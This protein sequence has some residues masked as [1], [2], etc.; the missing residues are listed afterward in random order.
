MRVINRLI[1]PSP[2]NR[3]STINKHLIVD[4]AL[5]KVARTFLDN[6]A[7][8][9]FSRRTC[10]NTGKINKQQKS[11]ATPPP[12]Y[13]KTWM[14]KPYYFTIGRLFTQTRARC[15]GQLSTT[16]NFFQIL[17]LPCICT[18]PAAC[19]S[20]I[21]SITS[22]QQFYYLL[23][24]LSRLCGGTISVRLRSLREGKREKNCY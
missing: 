1:F 16:L 10:N 19:R 24:L 6:F 2:V 11:C 15:V 3:Y 22:H 5:R 4:E 23:N 14:F 17:L 8:T 21:P 18:R 7:F 20:L 13:F 9:G 12:T